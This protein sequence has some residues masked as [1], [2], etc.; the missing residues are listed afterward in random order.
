[1]LKDIVI[2]AWTPRKKITRNQA[3][4]N[5][6]KEVLALTGK[7]E[8]SIKWI[9]L[10]RKFTFDD[11]TNFD[12]WTIN[13]QTSKEADIPEVDKVLA[14]KKSQLIVIDKNSLG[15]KNELDVIRIPF[16]KSSCFEIVV[17]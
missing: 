12:S 10:Y 17:K 4:I 3:D 8:D 5:S 11:T 1:M 13:D 6:L 7:M 14:S 2:K 9:Q 16:G 15:V